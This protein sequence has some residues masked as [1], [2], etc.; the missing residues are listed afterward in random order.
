MF[1]TLLL[2]S[3]N[4]EEKGKKEKIGN[5]SGGS[6]SFCKGN[7][8]TLRMMTLGVTTFQGYFFFFTPNSLVALKGKVCQKGGVFRERGNC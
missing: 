1:S 6:G 3:E 8:I 2:C 7:S 5:R 4:N